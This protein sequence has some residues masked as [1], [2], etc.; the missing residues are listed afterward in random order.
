[1]I[2]GPNQPSRIIQKP[3][4][5]QAQG[6]EPAAPAAPAELEVAAAAS[7]EDQKQD[8]RRP[9]SGS[10]ALTL[11]TVDYNDAG[12]IIFSGTGRSDSRI[13]LYVDNAS[14][15]EAA[16]AGDG[17]WTFAGKEQIKPGTHTLRVD[18]LHADGKVAQRIELPFMRAK[19]QQ[20]AALN[21]SVQAKTEPAGNEPTAPETP[22]EQTPSAAAVPVP[23]PSAVPLA[24]AEAAA[25]SAEISAAPDEPPAPEP[26]AMEETH[27]TEMAAAAATP[28]EEGT[29]IE[30]SASAEAAE[31]APAIVIPRK[32]QIVI[33][34]GNSLWRISRVIY[35]R[36]IEYTVIYEANRTQIRN[37]DLIYPGQIFAT[38]GAEPVGAIDP[39]KQTPLATSSSTPTSAE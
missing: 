31:T 7:S 17:T 15:G 8:A 37:P 2:S 4:A 5:A 6:E 34:P 23:D 33:Q 14:V 9:D 12:D 38:P 20:V 19:P 3:E 1:V 30:P 32:G 11:S 18:Q 22:A 16:V 26:S 28:V 24:E 21:E 13:R 36:G 27:G 29:A 25:P 10:M 39:A 35:G